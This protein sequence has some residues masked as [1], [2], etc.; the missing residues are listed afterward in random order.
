MPQLSAPKFI[1]LLGEPKRQGTGIGKLAFKLSIFFL[2]GN[3]SLWTTAVNSKKPRLTIPRSKHEYEQS[4]RACA[5]KQQSE[6]S[7][8]IGVPKEVKDNEFRVGL[9]PAGVKA[10]TDFPALF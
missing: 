2:N 6:R 8:I 4:F 7:M 5:A 3:L 10:L 1:C 9:V